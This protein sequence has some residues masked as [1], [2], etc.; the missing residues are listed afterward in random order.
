MSQDFRKQIVQRITRNFLDIL[1]LRLIQTEPM[2]GYKIIKKTERL[3]GIRIRH[4]ALYPLLN[5]LEAKG[6][7]RSIK[8]AKGGRVRKVYEITSK[9]IQLVDAYY[10]FLREQ[11]QKLDIKE[12]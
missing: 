6:Y 9:G 2:W 8:T 12:A 5:S 3:F 1:I 4:G 11:L 7:V 10:D